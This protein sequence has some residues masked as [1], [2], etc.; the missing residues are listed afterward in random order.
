[1]SGNAILVWVVA[2]LVAGRIGSPIVVV[3]R[4]IA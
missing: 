3:A 2:G 4:V 1:M